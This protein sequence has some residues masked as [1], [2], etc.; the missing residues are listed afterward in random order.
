MSIAAWVLVLS[1]LALTAGR[2][3]T[4]PPPTHPIRSERSDDS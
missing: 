1:I 4:R 3:L 2:E